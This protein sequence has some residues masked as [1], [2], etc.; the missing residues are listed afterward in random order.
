M[1][2]EKTQ[3]E[4]DEVRRDRIVWTTLIVLGVLVTA[5][6]RWFWAGAWSRAVSSAAKKLDQCDGAA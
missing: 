4:L 2:D 6:L 1:T 5:V 3:A